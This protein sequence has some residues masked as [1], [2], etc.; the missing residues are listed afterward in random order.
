MQSIG[1]S[2]I[3]TIRFIQERSK[4]LNVSSER[5]AFL[6]VNLLSREGKSQTGLMSWRSSGLTPLNWP[7]IKGLS[8]RYKPVPCV[9]R[10]S[11]VSWSSQKKWNE[12]WAGSTIVQCLSSSLDSYFHRSWIQHSFHCWDL[13]K[14]KRWR[15]KLSVHKKTVDRQA[16]KEKM[17]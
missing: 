8:L 3:T 2:C 15:F 16:H 11:I 7:S 10:P 9:D 1:F 12:I 17:V 13:W 6:G 5:S 14:G 4:D